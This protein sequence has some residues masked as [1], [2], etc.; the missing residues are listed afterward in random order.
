[1]EGSRKKIPCGPCKFTFVRRE[2]QGKI[3]AVTGRD[4]SNGLHRGQQDY[5]VAPGQPWLDGYCVEKGVIRQF[6]AMPLGAGYTA[7][8]Q[9]TGKAEQ[10]GLQVIV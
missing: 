2:K 9:I 3:N 7:E 6:V 10:G 8:E 5:M 1:M 4:W